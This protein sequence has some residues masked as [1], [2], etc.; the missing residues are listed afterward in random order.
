MNFTTPPNVFVVDSDAEVRAAMQCV[1][2]TV[3]LRVET[4]ESAKDLLRR[5][6]PQGP[7]CL[8]L[9]IWLPGMSGLDVQQK[10]VEAGTRISVI[11]VTAHADVPVAVKAMKWGAVEFLT[12]PFR[13]QDLVD[14][15]QHAL[16]REEATLQELNDIAA[17]RKLYATL[18]AREREVMGLI[19]SGAHTK[20]VGSMLGISEVTVAVHR[21]RFM[22]KM[23]TDSLA[24]LGRMAERLKLPQ[25]EYI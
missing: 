3:G 1:L 20:T 12:K 11:F 6:L 5:H 13:N 16:A 25:A 7:S 8:I 10:L 24:E 15:V 2:G 21:S 4:F 9:D 23:H 14:A 17:L 19:I 22:R 18:T